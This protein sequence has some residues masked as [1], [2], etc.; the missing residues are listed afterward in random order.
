MNDWS[1]FPGSDVKVALTTTNF[2]ALNQT[3]KNMDCPVCVVEMNM[4]LF[5]FSPRDNERFDLVLTDALKEMLTE[6]YIS[7]E[8]RIIAIGD[9]R[10]PLVSYRAFPI[11]EKTFE[12]AFFSRW[13]ICKTLIFEMQILKDKN[14]TL[15][16]SALYT[17]HDKK[18]SGIESSLN[19]KF[20]VFS[21]QKFSN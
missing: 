20:I 18:W 16:I 7:P 10:C 19:P 6:V 15:S 14:S 13:E 17:D 9:I 2:V 3:M 5:G 1:K 11:G 21:P 4:M 8:E 12:D